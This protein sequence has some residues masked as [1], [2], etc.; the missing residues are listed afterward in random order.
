[1]KRNASCLFTAECDDVD[2]VA[3]ADESKVE[4]RRKDSDYKRHWLP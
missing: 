2:V 4:E 3:D 1:M